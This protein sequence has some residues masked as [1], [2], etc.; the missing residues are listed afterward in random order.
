[1]FENE[2]FFVQLAE[3]FSN[4]MIFQ[5][6]KEICIFGTGKGDGEI[7]FCGNTIKFKSENDDFRVY[8]P[9]MEAGGPYEMMVTLNG[10][11]KVYNNILVGDVYLAG[12]QSNMEYPLKKII[13]IELV[14][15][16]NIRLF[17]EPH[18]Y[19]SENHR[20]C[21]TAKWY[22]CNCDSAKEFSAI[23][24]GFARY[25]Y[26]QSGVPVG[27]ISSNCGSA[28]VDAWTAP[29]IV[30]SGEYQSLVPAK[31]S[32]CYRKHFNR[33]S[34]LYINKLLP[35]VP[36]TISGVLWY[37]GEE[38]VRDEESGNYG[39]LLNTLI[40]NWRE[41]WN[42]ELPF[43]CVQIMPFESADA[44]SDWGAVRQGIEYVSKHTKKAYMT[45]LVRSGEANII[46]PVRKKRV[47]D[48]LA[49][50]VLC[51]AFG[52]RQEYC[53]PVYDTVEWIE[54][55]IKVSF[56]HADG[57]EIRG[58]YLE[59]TY[60]YDVDDVAYT[61]NSEITGTTLT[62][63]WSEN[64]VP[65]RVSMGYA[66]SPTHNLYNKDGYLASPFNLKN[67][68][69]IGKNCKGKINLLHSYINKEGEILC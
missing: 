13:D 10:E 20:T 66:N 40:E 60:V 48:A 38:N 11:T 49:K 43:Y 5:R 56:T 16:P 53:G 25:L 36:Y 17:T 24:Y 55:G 18:S 45:T 54:N 61:V 8:L 28:R 35:I 58:E 46:H 41:I 12:G 34:W 29:D 22:E 42:D 52:I 50:A 7:S 67:K 63:T 2:V 39:I 14:E 59:D 62:L 68:A 23:G 32:R 64:V 30:N 27:V 44:D 4:D 69:F 47:A 33:D 31:G 65:V 1:M 3:I 51:E 19:Y 37:Q 9:E 21:D 6:R 57:L 26:E 15:N